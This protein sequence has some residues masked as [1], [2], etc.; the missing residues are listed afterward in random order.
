MRVFGRTMT[1]IVA[2]WIL[3]EGQCIVGDLI[4][5][6]NALMVRR[7]VDAPLQNTTSMPMS[8]HLD[9]VGCHSVVNELPNNGI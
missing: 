8:R 5:E 1:Y 9:T 6:L 4:D 7:M 2:V 3:D